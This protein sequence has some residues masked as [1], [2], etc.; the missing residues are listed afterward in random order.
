M[1][2]LYIRGLDPATKTKLEAMAK[3]KEMSLNKY[4]IQILT[5]YAINPA[6]LAQ[7]EKYRNLI[8]DITG[9]Y[10][11]ILEETKEQLEENS[12]ILRK[13]SDKLEE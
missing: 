2:D 7:E 11:S 3:S 12:H 9:L 8:K 4:V 10:Q 1:S 6:L 13:V 5:D